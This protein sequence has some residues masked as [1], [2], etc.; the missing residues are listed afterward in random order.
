MPFRSASAVK[1]VH[2]EE[3][4]I[5]IYNFEFDVNFA[6]MPVS[7]GEVLAGEAQKAIQ[8]F[9]GIKGFTKANL[10]SQLKK[11][12]EKVL[13]G[14]NTDSCT[15]QII[16]NFGI[17]SSLFGKINQIFNKDGIEGYQIYLTITEH[18]DVLTTESIIINEG[19]D[20]QSCAEHTKVLVQK[21]ISAL[22]YRPAKSSGSFSQ[23]DSN[24][25]KIDDLDFDFSA[26]SEIKNTFT[27]KTSYLKVSS[28]PRGATVRINGNIEGNTP[29][30]QELMYGKY[31]IIIDSPG[32][33]P[34]KAEFDLSQ[35]GANLNFKLIPNFADIDIT[36]NPAGAEVWLNGESVGKTPLIL[37]KKTA[38]KKYHLKLSF[39]KYLPVEDEF[40][41]TAGKTQVIEKALAPNFGSLSISVDDEIERFSPQYQVYLDDTLLLKNTLSF[42]NYVSAGLHIIKLTA[43]GFSDAQFKANVKVS[44][45]TKVS[46]TSKPKWTK[47][48]VE[49]VMSL[50]SGNTPAFFPIFIDGNDTEQTTPAKLDVLEKEL[51]VS[52]KDCNKKRL[53]KSITP[54]MDKI[55]TMLFTFSADCL[56][57]KGI[58]QLSLPSI[59]KNDN[60]KILIDDN[61]ISLLKNTLTLGNHH[62]EIYKDDEKLTA[63][64]FEV[65]N[66]KEVL[67]LELVQRPYT[68]KEIF[69][70]QQ[71]HRTLSYISTGIASVSLAVGIPFLFKGISNINK[72]DDVAGQSFFF[73][74]DTYMKANEYELLKTD[75]ETQRNL[76]IAFTSIGIGTALWAIY[77]WFFS[78]IEQKSILWEGDTQRFVK[79]KEFE[80]YRPNHE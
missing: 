41:L 8:N 15:R 26:G 5:F 49:A 23:I 68:K 2:A 59:S 73:Q 40:F 52:V 6:G 16:E 34:Q 66:N 20:L 46:L 3:K 60:V 63:I 24:L 76:G 30:A 61:K 29:F 58:L 64:D 80:P 36:S 53:E 14:C 13:L 55:K 56:D 10:Q 33:L 38:G 4:Q 77:E 7:Y 42:L 48:K 25:V 70:H 78:D 21:M 75:G 69:E 12:E 31:I 27:D 1:P 50:A 57:A 47:I 11:E 65:K 54:S 39:P 35:K 37:K 71:H 67:E 79:D 28:E 19:F 72:V 17:A 43:P 18:D 9:K 74:N 45:T 62:L 51:I 22:G 44:E 32:Y